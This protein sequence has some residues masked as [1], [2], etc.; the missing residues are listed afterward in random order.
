MPPVLCGRHFHNKL[1]NRKLDETL[2][3]QTDALLFMKLY[4][5]KI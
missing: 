1:S 2:A 5:R 4:I 3:H